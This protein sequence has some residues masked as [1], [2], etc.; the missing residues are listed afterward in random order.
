MQ[1]KATPTPLPPKAEGYDTGVD[2]VACD[3]MLLGI[4]VVVVKF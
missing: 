3:R 1:A 2:H 4:L